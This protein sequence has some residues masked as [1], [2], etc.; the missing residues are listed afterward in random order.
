[1]TITTDLLALNAQFQPNPANLRRTVG[2]R[3]DTLMAQIVWF[4]RDLRVDDHAPL[5]KAA[6]SGPVVPLYVVEPEYWR[7]PDTSRRQWQFVRECLREL[8]D[9]LAR[10]GAPLVVRV[11]SVPEVL[12]AIHSE[13]GIDAIWSHEETGNAWTFARDRRVA[14]WAREHSVS[15]HEIPQNGVVRGLANRDGWARRWDRFMERPAVPAPDRIRAEVRVEPGTLPGPEDVGLRADTC[16]DRQVG[17]RSNALDLLHTFLDHRGAEYHKQMSSPLTAWNSCSRLSPHLAAGSVSMR[18]IAQAT[19]QRL[20]SLRRQP[21]SQRGCS[22]RALSA[23]VGRLHWHC[24][25]IQ[26]L[27][28]SPEH[29]RRNVHAGYDGLREDAFCEAR[30]SAWADGRTGFPFVDAC[31]RYLRACGWINFRM[32]AMLTAF[33]AY[34]L[35]LHW[36][37]PGL[38]LARLFTD[39]EAG[40]HWSQVQMQSGTTGINALRIYN[41]VKQSIDQD[42]DGIF[43][44]Q[45]V[46]ELRATPT[47]LIHEPWLMSAA[48]QASVGCTIGKDYP[49]RIVDHVAA[50]RE[51]RQ[52]FQVVR[53]QDA[54]RVEADRIQARHG[55]RKRGHRR[56]AP[57]S[58]SEATTGGGR[59]G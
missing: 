54:F 3:L 50:G 58:G 41:P 2:I 7:E 30:F 38:H 13:V 27:E 18:E 37:E 51:A 46:P 4:K 57:A 23:F 21:R 47:P 59:Q 39:Y 53:R 35:W 33:A 29:E 55:S 49:A 10:H 45:W 8:G 36:R 9:A 52:R 43:I 22:V 24:H 11:G 32:R 12:K 44:R 14:E 42:P 19:K 1:M 17:G 25:F 6:Q 48:E 40:I 26:K 56:N 31:M 20:E 34:H 16:P 15:W 28:D 5:A